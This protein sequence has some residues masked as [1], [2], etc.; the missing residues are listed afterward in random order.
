MEKQLNLCNSQHKYEE[1]QKLT[2]RKQMYFSWMNIKKWKSNLQNEK[3]RVF[4]WWTKVNVLFAS[5]A[6]SH[7]YTE[8]DRSWLFA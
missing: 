8:C 3:T 5:V 4:N 6:G 2:L 7:I 1:I